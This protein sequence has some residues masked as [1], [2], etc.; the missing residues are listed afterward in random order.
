LHMLA[1]T[2]FVGITLSSVF[3]VRY[4]LKK[5][6]PKKKIDIFKVIFIGD[7][8]VLPFL[9]IL[10]GTGLYL[11]HVNHFSLV[12]PWIFVALVTFGLVS[13]GWLMHFLL[14]LR[15]F[16]QLKQGK[17]GFKYF[18]VLYCVIASVMFLLFLMMMHDAITQST[19]FG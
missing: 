15:Y 11:V 19:L 14:R 5:A 6:D 13:I 12:L 2:G 7:V 17:N 3:F 8:F 10:F 1:V 16:Y 9:V 4:A 18:W